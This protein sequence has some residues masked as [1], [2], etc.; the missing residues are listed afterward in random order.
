MTW[1]KK[2]TSTVIVYAIAATVFILLSLI[3]PFD[4]PAA[5]WVM[6]S[7]SIVAIAAGAFISI[8]AFG[9]SE[10]LVSKF[11]GYPLFRIGFIY[12]AIQIAATIIVYIIGAFVSVPYW[13]GV[14]L[15][16]LLMGMA[17]IGCIAA[18]NARD[19]IEDIDT[20][21]EFVTKTVTLFQNDISDI[22]D[23][24]KNEDV[25]E[26]LARLVTKFKYSDPVS[27]EATAEKEKQIK[28]AVEKLK[29]EIV[30]GNSEDLI[31]QIENIDRLLSSRNRICERSK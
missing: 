8:Y 27:S 18:D 6:F 9:K 15:S 2:K 23:I 11:Y 7:F 13:V 17:A 3:I 25:K 24:C 1:N 26:P 31:S 28:D 20:R 19:F 16:V 14:M 30:T 10:E 4:K 29:N 5:S 21:E 12:A 22:M